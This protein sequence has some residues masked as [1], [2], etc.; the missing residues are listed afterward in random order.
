MKRMRCCLR[1]AL[2]LLAFNGIAEAQS[3][4]R[5]GN[6]ARLTG[7]FSSLLLHAETQDVIGYE[8]TVSRVGD[9]GLYFIVLQCAQ[10]VAEPPIVS[11]AEVANG[12]LTF[13]PSDRACGSKFRLEPGSNGML[14]WVDGQPQ[15][16]IPR[17]SSF[18]EIH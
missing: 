9:R 4:A 12:V 15:G 11:Q 2:T 14:L 18:W 16:T 3:P 8:I 6:P 10:G 17:H 1:V 5:N 7:V 13:S